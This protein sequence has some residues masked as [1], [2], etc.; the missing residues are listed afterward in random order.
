MMIALATTTAASSDC[1][2]TYMMLAKAPKTNMI[3]P[4]KLKTITTT[5]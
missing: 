2:T 1:T 3:A 5:H 4:Y